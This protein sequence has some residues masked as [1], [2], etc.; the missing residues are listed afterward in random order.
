MQIAL[1]IA[2]WVIGILAVLILLLY[3]VGGY[4]LY[5]LAIKR[6]DKRQNKCWELPLGKRD[7]ESDEDFARMKEGEA[8]VKGRLA[9]FVTITS[10]D[11]LKLSARVYEHP[12]ARG[13]FLMVHGYRSSSLGDFSG[14]IKSVYDMGYSLFLIDQR[15]HG[16]SEGGNI[17]FGSFE[18][19]D[20]VDWANYIKERWP[21]LPV[22]MDGVSMGS[23]TVMLA[24]GVGYPDNVRAIIADCGYTTPGAI[25]RDV[26]RK[27]MHI[28]AFPVYYGGRLWTKL[29]AKYDLDKV[30]VPDA[31]RSLT[32][33]SLYPKPIP[34]L[35]AH[36]RKDGFVPYAMSEE[37]VKSLEDKD[38]HVLPFA[39]FFTSEEA[40]HGMSFLKDYDAYMEAIGRL[41]DK[42]GLPHDKVEEEEFVPETPIDQL[43]REDADSGM[44]YTIN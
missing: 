23:G 24:C 42:A 31:L 26:L 30:S 33:T 19:Y 11:G 5:R 39:E 44:I 4:Y 29:L 6:D 1:Q 3:F 17:C 38:G 25:C 27:H 43:T 15:G 41:F 14:A 18:R 13:M 36:G 40:D 32:D 2:A 34:I 12:D 21:G 9:E 8:L 35:I 16:R 37:N 22:V 20:V 28:P 10:R 7:E